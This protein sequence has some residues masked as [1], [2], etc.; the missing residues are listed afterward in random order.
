MDRMC[1]QSFTFKRSCP[2]TK[3]ERLLFLNQIGHRDYITGN[4]RWISGEDLNLEAN[5]LQTWKRYI[6]S[7]ENS[8]VRLS[9][10]ED[11]LIWSFNPTGKYSPKHGYLSLIQ[12]TKQEPPPWW[13]KLLWK[14]KC[15]Q[16]Q[17]YSCGSF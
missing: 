3:S 10:Q 1:Q 9:D 11:Q 2:L 6:I 5:S 7:L 16:N 13:G 15:P 14:L 12:A 8:F 4:T 17:S